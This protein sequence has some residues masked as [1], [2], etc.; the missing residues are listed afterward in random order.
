MCI[1]DRAKSLRLFGKDVKLSLVSIGGQA[2]VIDSILYKLRL[3]N[4]EGFVIEVE[5][6][7][8]QKISSQ[9]DKVDHK[10]IAEIFQMKPI[11]INRPNSGEVDV[12][13]GQ[14][15]ASLHPVRIK[16]VGDLILMKNEFGYVVSGFHPQLDM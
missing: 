13:I 1:R 8:I 2:T 15:A 4:L 3:V 16:A 7:G 5:A 12:L 10:A 9:I 11:G 6:Y 14:Q